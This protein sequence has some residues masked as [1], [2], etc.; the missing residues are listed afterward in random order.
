MDDTAGEEVMVNAVHPRMALSTIEEK[1]G[2]DETENKFVQ[3][4]SEVWQRRVHGYPP[5]RKWESCI[6]VRSEGGKY[7]PDDKVMGFI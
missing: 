5:Q 7:D 4:Q 3:E 6:Q 1:V 2:E